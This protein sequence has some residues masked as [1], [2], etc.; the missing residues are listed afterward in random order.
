VVRNYITSALRRST[1]SYQQQHFQP[2]RWLNAL[3]TRAGKF[4][5]P[6]YGKQ[7]PRLA[8]WPHAPTA[9]PRLARKSSCPVSRRTQAGSLAEQNSTN[10]IKLKQTF[11]NSLPRPPALQ[12]SESLWASALGPGGPGRPSRAAGRG[13]PRTS[14][15]K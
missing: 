12:E 9:L 8:S 5:C 1:L 11:V 2:R 7:H 14:S 10:H 15:D 6:H 13:R 4:K 3:H